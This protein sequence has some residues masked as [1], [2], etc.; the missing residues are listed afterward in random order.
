MKMKF[1]HENYYTMIKKQDEKREPY[2]TLQCQVIFC[3]EF[4]D[5]NSSMKYV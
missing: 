3:D 2:I 5:N 1:T 4:F